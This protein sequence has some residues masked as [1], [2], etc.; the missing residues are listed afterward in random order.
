MLPNLTNH[1]IKFSDD[2]PRSSVRMKFRHFISKIFVSVLNSELGKGGDRGGIF[3][4][5]IAVELSCKC[6]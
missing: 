4:V 1:Y 2:D 6:T 3:S 5:T